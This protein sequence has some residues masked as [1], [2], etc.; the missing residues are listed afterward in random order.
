[1]AVQQDHL[2]EAFPDGAEKRDTDDDGEASVR[3]ASALPVSP[4]RAAKQPHQQ[5][6][7]LPGSPFCGEQDSQGPLP[8]ASKPILHVCQ[9]W[10]DPQ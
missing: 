7:G 2:G 8:H 1:M 5:E 10:S 4:S 6:T 9:L 3:G